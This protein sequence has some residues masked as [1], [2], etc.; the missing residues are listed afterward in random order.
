MIQ[1]EGQGQRKWSI[2]AVGE[3]LGEKHGGGVVQMT[4]TI[5]GRH[6]GP[7]WGQAVDRLM[8][9]TSGPKH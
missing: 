7:D 4:M 9:S 2:V 3:G 5:K 8:D 1:A 6:G